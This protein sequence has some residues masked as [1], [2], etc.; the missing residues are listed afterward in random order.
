MK[1][2]TNRLENKTRDYERKIGGRK[3]GAIAAEIKGFSVDAG[4]AENLE[5]ILAVSLK[6]RVNTGLNCA[7]WQRHTPLQWPEDFFSGAG[8][9]LWQSGTVCA[10]FSVSTLVVCGQAAYTLTV[11]ILTVKSTRVSPKT[12]R[13][14]DIKTPIT[15]GR[16]NPTP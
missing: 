3:I 2:A 16:K 10:V 7:C 8:C 15:E 12:N 1:N 4:G 14:S 13:L 11:N 5:T 6:T 9:F